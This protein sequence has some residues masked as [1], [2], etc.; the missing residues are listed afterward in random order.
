[1]PEQLG[2][3][4]A[5]RNSATIDRDKLPVFAMTQVM[6]DFGKRFFTATAFTGDENSHVG[7]G[8]LCCNSQGIIELRGVSDDAK[9]LF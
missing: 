6:N 8:D 2:I 5:F 4:G 1:M 7:R 9:A 3:N